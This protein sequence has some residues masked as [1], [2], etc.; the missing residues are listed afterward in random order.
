MYGFL[1][2]ASLIAVASALLYGAIPSFVASPI[3]LTQVPISAMQQAITPGGALS[4]EGARIIIVYP[5]QSQRL[6]AEG[7]FGA[8]NPEVSF[9]GQSILFAGKQTSRDPWSIFEIGADGQGLRQITRGTGNCRNPVYLSTL[10]TL[11]SDKP[12]HQ[13][14]FVSDLSGVLDEYAANPAASLYSCRLDGTGRLRLTF[15]PSGAMDPFLMPDGRLILASLRRRH[16]EETATLALFGVNIDGT[17]FAL[18]AGEEGRRFKRM[19]CI[20]ADGL[21]VFVETD[22]A[23]SDDAGFLSCVSLRRNHHS[24]RQITKAADGHFLYPSPLPDG[25]VLVSRLPEAAGASYGI[26]EIDPVSGR[27]D[28]VFDDPAFHDIQAKVLAPR[29]EPDGRSTSVLRRTGEIEDPS[30]LESKGEPKKPAEMPMGKLYSLNVYVSNLIKAEWMPPGTVKRARFLEGIPLHPRDLDSLLASGDGTSSNEAALSSAQRI[31]MLPRRFLGEVPVED[32]GSFNV[33]VPADIPIEI[34]LLDAHG[35]ALESC[36]WIWVKN[37]EP[38]GCIGCH[39]DPELVPENRLVKAVTKPSVQLTLPPERR[40]TV[41]FMHDVAPIIRVKCISC[42]GSG[43]SLPSLDENLEADTQAGEA[44][45][46]R[47]YATLIAPPRPASDPGVSGRAYVT[48]GKARTSSLIWHIIGRNTSRPWDRI[49]FEA[50]AKMMPLSSAPSLNEIE[51][52]TFIEWIDMGAPWNS[53]ATQIE[54]SLKK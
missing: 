6:L 39:E 7:F 28:P 3:V 10:Y 47:T 31:P 41:D 2:R 1:T 34:Q 5:D 44:A 33:Q 45:A 46:G 22:L 19:P 16:P 30:A 54:M 42:H 29:Q 20:T 53:R 48:P 21:A 14:A 15:S 35:I 36:G 17:D 12:W 8:C 18:I 52:R 43:G 27:F 32:D 40:R 4:C 25:K 26:Y 13:I 49:L 38:R 11:I 51:K 50:K 23:A 37:N 24:Y 9:D